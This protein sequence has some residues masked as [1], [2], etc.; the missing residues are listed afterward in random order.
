MLA[1]PAGRLGQMAQGPRR[2]GLVRNTLMKETS[3]GAAAGMAQTYRIALEACDAG[4]PRM[5]NPS[6]PFAG[7]PTHYATEARAARD[8]SS[9]PRRAAPCRCRLATLCENPRGSS[10]DS[11]SGRC[12]TACPDLGVPV[13]EVSPRAVESVAGSFTAMRLSTSVDA[14][15]GADGCHAGGREFLQLAA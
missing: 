13:D 15:G 10:I 6:V 7:E 5:T 9:S 2:R 1:P 12:A 8:S 3:A 11:T 4:T 14:C